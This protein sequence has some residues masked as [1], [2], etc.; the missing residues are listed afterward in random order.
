MLTK[1][2]LRQIGEV[3]EVKLRPIDEKVTGLD[4]K[5]TKLEKSQKALKKTLNRVAREQ[6]AILGFLNKEDVETRKRVDRIED[7]LGLSS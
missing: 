5:V 6:Q 2:D 3:I 7:Y 1:Q 4:E